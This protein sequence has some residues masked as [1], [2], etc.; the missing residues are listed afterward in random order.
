M[1]YKKNTILGNSSVLLILLNSSIF[2]GYTI[3][4]SLET[5]YYLFKQALLILFFATYLLTCNEIKINYKL[6][7]FSF[8]IV[9]S[10]FIFNENIDNNYH[11]IPI[12][13]LAIFIFNH[14]NTTFYL[15]YFFLFINFFVI[16]FCILTLFK[17]NNF[18]NFKNAG[19]IIAGLPGL[20]YINN[21]FYFYLNFSIL[22]LISLLSLE[23]QIFIIL[24]VILFFNFAKSKNEKSLNLLFFILI[25]INI[26]LIIFLVNFKESIFLN[27][28]FNKRPIVFDYYIQLILNTNIKNLFF[29][30]GYLEYGNDFF[31]TMGEYFN[32]LQ[33][34]F[35]NFSPHN[36]IIISIYTYGLF[37]LSVILLFLYKF[38]LL[39]Q[40]FIEKKILLIFLIIGTLQSFN[41]LTHQPVSILFS[42]IVITVLKN[43]SD[44]NIQS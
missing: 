19:F 1:I 40:R 23:R 11:L 12:L 15:K 30:H 4:F 27:E 17:F 36:F 20:L 32:W 16:F 10:S 31:F 33:L 35:R 2:F 43:R 44:I 34:R 18:V 38:F 14:Q 21:K 5:D 9:L 29:G 8:F 42:L 26:T 22:T 13:Y 24:L 37:G 7:F 25:F 6:L 41:F 28:V 3:L 39:E